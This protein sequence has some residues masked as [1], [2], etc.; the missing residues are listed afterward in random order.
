M[1]DSGTPTLRGDDVSRGIL[2]EQRRDLESIWE[3]RFPGYRQGVNP[4]WFF[5]LYGYRC[6][7]LPRGVQ[8]LVVMFHESGC[9]VLADGSRADPSITG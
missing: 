2:N 7:Y 6:I 5:S 3:R 9:V 4:S 8:V 1:Q